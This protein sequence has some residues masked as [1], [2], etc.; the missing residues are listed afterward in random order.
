M[1][2]TWA[3]ERLGDGGTAAL[4]GLAIG[5]I[6]GFCA[7]RSHFCLRASTIEFWRGSLGPRTAVWLLV[8]GAALIGT[9]LLFASKLLDATTI[10][11]L[12]Q[13]GTL[14]GAIIGG[15]M[16]GCGMILARGCAS[17]LLVLSAAGNLRALVAGLILTVAA[18]AALSGAL[19]PLRLELA[20]WWTVGPETRDMA[21]FLPRHAGLAI[22]V[23]TIALALWLAHHHGLAITTVLTGIGVGA[24]IVLAWWFN[25]TLASQAFDIVPVQGV[26]F[27]GPSADTLMVLISQPEVTVSFG[28]GLVPGVFAGSFL[29]AVTAG[30]FRIE[31]FNDEVSLPRYI[32]GAIL[33][34]FG[35]MLAGGCAVGAGVTGGSVMALTAW[36]ALLFM[37]LAAGLTDVLL[38]RPSAAA[39]ETREPASATPS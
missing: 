25:A 21:T 29:S 20:S 6:F 18:Q 23:P 5:L 30:E 22:A 13:T 8:F 3:L 1:D 28:L 34:G 9:Q 2:F 39:T 35:S 10:R 14:S 12:S 19:S 24:A 33:M 27:S 11:Q 32:I 38:D 26:S 31:T 37:W 4:G 16:F 15:A 7:Q 36:I 17:R